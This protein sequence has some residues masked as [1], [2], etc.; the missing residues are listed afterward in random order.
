MAITMRMFPSRLMKARRE[1]I[2]MI[3]VVSQEGVARGPTEI[4]NLNKDKT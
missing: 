2:M 3:T 4:S 1:Q